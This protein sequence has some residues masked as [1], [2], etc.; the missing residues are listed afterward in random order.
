LTE[1]EITGE[2]ITRVGLSL[3]LG[4]GLGIVWTLIFIACMLNVTDTFKSAVLASVLLPTFM[5]IG[6][7]KEWLPQ[8]LKEPDE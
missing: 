6:L 8:L 1:D 4:I 7:W 5:A 2:P 3:R